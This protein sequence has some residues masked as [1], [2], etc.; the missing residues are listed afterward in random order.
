[1]R[2]CK[3]D[4]EERSGLGGTGLILSQ[5]VAMMT[6]INSELLAQVKLENSDE[7]AEQMSRYEISLPSP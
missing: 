3:I 7:Q 5:T 4:Q 1:M 2:A 6:T